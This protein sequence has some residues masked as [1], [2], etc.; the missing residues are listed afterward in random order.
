MSTVS[1][2]NGATG[3]NAE[4]QAPV[5]PQKTLN[6]NDFF[7]LLI[8]QMTAQDPMNP[9]SNEDFM[10][11]MA[12]FSSLEQTR[13]MG[14][15]IASMRDEQQM[16]QANSLIGR[17]VNLQIDTGVVHGTVTAVQM[18]GT[19]PKIVVGDAAYDLSQVLTIT[20]SSPAL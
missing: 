3:A 16:L 14:D 6:Q 11:Q 7:K 8:A 18:D 2:I 19:T 12:Q 17:D 4:T 15:T 20:A 1:G 9:M 10:G 5:L 13:T